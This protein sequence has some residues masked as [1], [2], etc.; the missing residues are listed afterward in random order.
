MFGRRRGPRQPV[1]AKARIVFG[2]VSLTIGA[3]L[4]WLS[5]AANATE[6]G[7][8]TGL[9]IVVAVTASL[10]LNLIL[11]VLAGVDGHGRRPASMS[12]AM[13]L[14]LDGLSFVFMFAAA[15]FFALIARVSAARGEVAPLLVFGLVS[16]VFGAALAWMLGRIVIRALRGEPYDDTHGLPQDPHLPS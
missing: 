11:G 7:S 15:A 2:A 8:V 14:A 6:R 16:F 10:G 9:V 13:R 4:V 12:V 1:P 5:I 3:L